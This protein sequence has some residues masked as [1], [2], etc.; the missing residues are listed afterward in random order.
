[1]DRFKVANLKT[2][3]RGESFP[4][5]G[6]LT[7]PETTRLRA[8]LS[9]MLGTD[10]SASG[11]ELVRL[12]DAITVPI[13]GARATD[14]DFRFDSLVEVL[15]VSPNPLVYVNWHHLD[16]VDELGYQDLTKHFSSIWYP[17]SDDIEVLDDTCSWVITISH[18]GYP[19]G[20]RLAS[21]DASEGGA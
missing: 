21:G 12:I 6:A 15:S 1:M 10:G 5:V 4:D 9:R 13:E 8:K 20:A 14:P 11:T 18:E 17:G 2:L 16:D 3:Y 7:T 19:A